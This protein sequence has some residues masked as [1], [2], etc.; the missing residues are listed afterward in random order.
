MEAYCLCNYAGESK[1]GFP[2]F[3]EARH[4]DEIRNFRTELDIPNRQLS[5]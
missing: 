4:I 1:I 5:I 2:Q 3:Y